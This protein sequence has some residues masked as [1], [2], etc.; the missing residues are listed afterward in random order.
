M[1]EAPEFSPRVLDALRTPLES[2]NVTISRS[3]SS[4]RYPAR[5]QLV[6]AANPCPCGYYGVVGSQCQCTPMAVRRYAQRISGPVLDR[7]DIHVQLTRAHSPRLRQSYQPSECTA[8][9]KE[10]VCGARGRQARRLRGT[11]WYTN[12][13]V[14]GSYIRANWPSPHG[15]ELIDAAF[16]RG[17]LTNRGIDKVVK[18]AW[19]MADLEGTDTVTK[20]QLAAAMTLRHSPWSIGAAS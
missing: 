4:V 8:A 5:F 2:G 9:I 11:P 6:L 12:A 16:D 17:L 15:I 14:P 7:V 20:N 18:V 13:E 10:R 1:D 19:T 3:G